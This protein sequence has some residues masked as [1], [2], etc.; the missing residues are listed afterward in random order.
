MQYVIVCSVDLCFSS[1]LGLYLSGPQKVVK[2]N[3]PFVS[4][5]VFVIYMLENS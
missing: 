5:F 4:K 3:R 2:E 1:L